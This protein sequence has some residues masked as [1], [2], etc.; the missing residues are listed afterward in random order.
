MITSASIL[1]K[2]AR[3]LFRVALLPAFALALTV[4]MW[5]GVLYQSS[6]ERQ[7][8][9]GEAVAH[10]Q[11]LS[12]VLAEHVSHILRQSGHAT[13]LFGLKYL[14][15]GGQYSLATF[16]VRGGLLDSVLP[17]RLDLPMAVINRDGQTIDTLNGFAPGSVAD[18][19][20]FS[21][22]ANNGSAPTLLSTPIVDQASGKWQL[23][24][25][26]ALAGPEGAFAGAVII[27]IDPYLFVDDYDRLNVGENGALILTT[28]GKAKALSAGRTGERLFVSSSLAFAPQRAPGASSEEIVPLAPLDALDATPRIYSQSP[29]PRY[30]LSAVVGIETGVAMAAFERHHTRY[31]HIALGASLLIAVI[32]AIL[33]RQSAQLRTAV[34]AARR[35]QATL[36]AASD[37]SLDGL[38]I[39]AAW[40]PGAREVQDF[41]IEHINERGAALF[42]QSRAALLGQKAF[43]L[44]PRYRQTG[45]FARYVQVYREGRP[46]EEEVEV[47]LDDDAPRWIHHQIVPLDTGVAVTSRD[48]SARKRS[49]IEIHNSRSFLQSLIDHL[50][51]LV[52]VKSVREASKGTMMVWNK[53]AEAATGFAAADVLGARDGAVFPPGF[54]FYNPA[55]DQ[56]M[57]ARP[58]VLDLPERPL[59]APDGSARYLRSLTVPLF[60][61]HGKMEFILYIAEDVTQKRA[62]QQ[63][64]RAGEAHLA[65]VTNASPLGL[66]RADVRGN[67][68]YVNRRFETITGLTREESLGLGWLDALV[69]DR[70]AYM[71]LVFEHQRDHEEPYVQVSHVRRRDGKMIWASTKTAAIRID[72]RI[73]GFIGTIDDITTLREAEMALRE[74]EARLRTIADTLPTMVA[75]LDASEIYRFHNRAYD[76]EFGRNGIEVLGM[77]VL[78]TVGPER[79]AVLAPYVRRALAGETLTF[80]EHDG[81]DGLERTLEVTYIPQYGEDGRSVVGFHVMRHDTT[82]QQR[83]KNRLLKLAQVDQLTGLANRAGFLHKLAGAMRASAADKRLMALMYMDIDHFK[84]VNDTYGHHV[85]DGLLK[86]F[87][88][89]LLQTLRASDVIARIGGDEF[90]II[91]EKLGRREDAAILADKVVSAMQAPF[92]LDGVTVSVSASIGLV[93][94]R[95]EDI[96]PDALIRQA[97]RLLYQAKEAGRNTYRSAA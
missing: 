93:F 25:V 44:L 96:D 21:A 35:A 42:G 11:A 3:R 77:S 46:V 18:E 41:V 23:R 60:D 1:R 95:D 17:V 66:I 8:S 75:Y 4:A 7:A 82:S 20:F 2:S 67:C 90:T 48:I 24:V 57:L 15:T 74:S 56:A 36:R 79:Y 27:M 54:A 22:L 32:V 78:A 86:A 34:R 14:E 49:E 84:P 97:D 76:R 40:P 63:S 94:Y 52:A 58:M 30:N 85:G 68:T 91:T 51:L 92:E 83:E 33:M 80:E 50:P 12:R 5:V 69:V 70:A 19:A 88:A 81:V 43:A 38:L 59:P 64:L 26:R 37:G 65:A 31:L 28:R 87:S 61:D 13:Q 39:L 55:E 53:A 10:S 73:T 72:G 62:Q 29:V 89:R 9:H 6:L 16:A 71:R 45:F 47:R